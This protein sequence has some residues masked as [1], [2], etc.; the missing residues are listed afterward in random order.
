[1]VVVLKRFLGNT[2]MVLIDFFPLTIVKMNLHG[3][4]SLKLMKSG[5]KLINQL[6]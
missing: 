1:M 3:L 5:Q 6:A 4:Y 2:Q